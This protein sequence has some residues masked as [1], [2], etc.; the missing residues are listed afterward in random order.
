[1]MKSQAMI[2]GA[3]RLLSRSQVA[4]GAHRRV[5]G[6]GDRIFRL[7]DRDCFAGHRGACA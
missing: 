5:T 3:T 4:H 6:L 2:S 1:M 7:G